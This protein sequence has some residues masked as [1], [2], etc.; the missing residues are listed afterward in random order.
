[1]AGEFWLSGA[2]WR[3][4]GQFG[5]RASA[6]RKDR[7]YIRVDG[8]P[9]VMIYRPGILPNSLAT[10]RRWRAAFTRAGDPYIVMAQSFSDDDPRIHGI[11]AAVEF[12]PHKLWWTPPITP[13]STT[14]SREHYGLNP[15]ARNHMTQKLFAQLSSDARLLIEEQV[16]IAWGHDEGLDAISLLRK[17]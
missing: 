6:V 15:S 16:V 11:D 8:R 4:I 10:M 12:P 7:R 17:P 5:C 13:D 3:A 2:Q 9:L 14:T 1:M